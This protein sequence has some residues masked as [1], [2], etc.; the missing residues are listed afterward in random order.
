M[1]GGHSHSHDA[2]AHAHDGGA[3]DHG[4]THEILDGPGSFL[5]REM[6]IV[7]CRD[8]KE[9]AFTVGIGG[10]VLL[11]PGTHKV[12]FQLS[13]DHQLTRMPPEVR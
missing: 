1:S 6:T 8:F 12:H 4:H 11:V 2:H 10:Y 7:E 5:G 3:V 13:P 9:R